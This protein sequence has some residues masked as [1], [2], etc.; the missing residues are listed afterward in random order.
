[1]NSNPDTI[2]NHIKSARVNANRSMKACA[3]FLRINLD[4]YAAFETGTLI[5]SLPEIELLAFFL[6]VPISIIFQ[7]ETEPGLTNLQSLN[8]KDFEELLKLRNKIIG[9]K[10]R[11]LREEK[12]LSASE[13][14]SQAGFCE[15]DLEAYELGI[16]PIRLSILQRILDVLECSFLELTDR[17]TISSRW[18]KEMIDFR[19]S[20]MLPQDGNF[21]FLDKLSYDELNKIHIHISDLI[22]N[23]DEIFTRI[24][25][26]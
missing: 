16:T 21:E 9:A 20:S 2:I 19:K 6:N 24:D 12:N 4:R 7:S 17:D 13:L 23:H 1:M 11:I 22:K 14:A 18:N 8:Q 25:T 3:D 15:G 26:E 10:I 5:P